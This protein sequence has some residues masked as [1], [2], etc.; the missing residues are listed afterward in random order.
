MELIN[1]EELRHT[2]VEAWLIKSSTDDGL[3]RVKAGT[4][5]KIF[6]VYPAIITELVTTHQGKEVVKTFIWADETDT[7]GA[8]WVPVEMIEWLGKEKLFLKKEVIH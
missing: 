8:G 1:F 5:G 7:G 3:I 6:M 2:R 4:T